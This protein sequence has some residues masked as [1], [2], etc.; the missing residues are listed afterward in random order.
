MKV[1]HVLN[2]SSFSGAENIAIT[3]INSTKETVDSCYVAFDGDI[4]NILNKNNIQFIPIKKMSISEIRRAVKLFRPDILHAHDFTTSVVAA[5]SFVKAPIISHLH[6]NTPWIKT[7]CPKS[8]MYLLASF[9]IVKILGVSQS[10]FDE[11][12]FGKIISKKAAVIPNSID[13]SAIIQKSKL[14]SSNNSIYDIAYLGRLSQ[15]KNPLRFIRIIEQMLS[16]RPELKAVMI[17]A[18]EMEAECR[19]QLLAKGLTDMVD[20]L[21][22]LENPYPILS[23]VKMLVMPS[24]WEGFG[25]AAVEALALGVPVIAS[26]VG[27]LVDIVTEKCGKLC[28]SDDEFVTEISRLLDDMDY[29]KTK[30]ENAFKR[31][32]E[33]DNNEKYMND[34]LEIYKDI[35]R[36]V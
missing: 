35:C 32:V 22:F 24:L 21:G 14:K 23:R 13:T 6:N 25:L 30:S 34:L 26:P 2:T 5:L 36:L 27:G 31:A 4:R 28:Q 16:V 18:G 11:Y 19:S 1:M 17:G 33:M 7:I 29:R 8:I 9:R 12:I 15:Q 20:M 3:I 10:I